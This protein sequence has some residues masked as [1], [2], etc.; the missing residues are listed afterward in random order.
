MELRR[1]NPLASARSNI[2]GQCDEQRTGGD[3]RRDRESPHIARRRA[4]NETSGDRR[5]RN[6]RCGDHLRRDDGVAMTDIRLVEINQLVPV[7]VT[8][9]WL[10]TPIGGL[11][12]T[13]A[14]ATAVILA[15]GTDALAGA[16]DELPGLPPDDDRRGWWAD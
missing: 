9:D 8:F 5:P 11:D 13:Q 16:D 6:G 14:L 10:L 1:G 15:L 3:R 12:D 2:D 7:V 4:R